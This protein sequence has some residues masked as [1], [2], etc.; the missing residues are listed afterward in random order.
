MTH[1]ATKSQTLPPSVR[2]VME[3]IRDVDEPSM[4]DDVQ[5]VET[6]LEHA[7]Q[8][9]QTHVLCTACERAN[10]LADRANIQLSLSRTCWVYK[11]F[12]YDSHY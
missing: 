10:I 12:I 11:N 3:W 5:C 6:W 9:S 4:A 8:A 7:R 1:E 2:I